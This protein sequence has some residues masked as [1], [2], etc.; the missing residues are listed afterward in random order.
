MRG[1][2]L[3]LV[4]GRQLLGRAGAAPQKLVAVHVHRPELEGVKLPPAGAEHAAPVN[5]RP[6]GVELDGERDSRQHRQKQ[7]EPDAGQRLVEQGLG[8]GLLA[9]EPV[10]LQA[11]QGNGPNRAHRHPRR[12]HLIESGR[13]A[14][15]HRQRIDVFAQP[16]QLLAA[17]RRDRDDDVLDAML[18]HDAGDVRDGAQDGEAGAARLPAVRRRHEVP[19]PARPTPASR[20]ETP[21]GW[22]PLRSS[23]R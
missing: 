20:G 10:L 13:Q 9:I 5:H 1:I 16:Q 17:R 11:H 3:Q 8:E 2:V 21:R 15:L 6:V 14:Q 18:P 22:P 12:Q 4:V 23:R 19:R 7:E